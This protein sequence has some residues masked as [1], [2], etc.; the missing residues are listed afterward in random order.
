MQKRQ[1]SKIK[2]AR[3]TAGILTGNA[4][5]VAGTPGLGEATEMLVELVEETEFHSGGQMNTGTELTAR[6]NEARAALTVSTLK[7]AAALAA[8]STVSADPAVKL[9]KTKYQVADSEIKK[10][11]DMPLF[12]Y[13]NTVF[14]DAQPF[15]NMLA[16]FATASDIEGLKTLADN[17]NAL[18]PQKRT[19][20]SKSALSTQNLEDAIARIDTL[21]ND[22]ID[23]LVKPWEYSQPDFF[24]AYTNARIIMDAAS[25]KTTAPPV[26]PPANQD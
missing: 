24:R 15:A 8:Y 9:L 23:V 7:V 10:L 12:T 19:Q 25:R 3:A 22:T 5:I 2:M 16:P 21:L 18:L 20:Q 26:E 11:R 13:A 1:E 14:A 4:E 17:F 6:K